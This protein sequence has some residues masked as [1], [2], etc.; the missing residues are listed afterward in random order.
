MYTSEAI[1]PLFS[2]VWI[3]QADSCRAARATWALQGE[4]ECRDILQHQSL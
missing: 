1:K 2:G 4:D 3:V